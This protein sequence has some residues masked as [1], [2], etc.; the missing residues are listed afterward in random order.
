[1]F[2]V[3]CVTMVEVGV[4]RQVEV[5][6]DRQAIPTIIVLDEMEQMR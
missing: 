4:D 1:V 6:L 3:Q 2:S 5:C